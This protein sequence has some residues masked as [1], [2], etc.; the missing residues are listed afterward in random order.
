MVRTILEEYQDFV[1]NREMDCLWGIIDGMM[2]VMIIMRL[3]VCW[4]VL[5]PPSLPH[6][7]PY[8]PSRMDLNKS[9]QYWTDTHSILR[10]AQTSLLKSTVETRWTDCRWIPIQT[11]SPNPLCCQ[12]CRSA[13]HSVPAVSSHRSIPYRTLFLLQSWQHRTITSWRVGLWGYRRRSRRCVRGGSRSGGCRGWYWSGGR[14][15]GCLVLPGPLRR[16]RIGTSQCFPVLRRWRIGR[17]CLG[18]AGRACVG[19]WWRCVGRGSRRWRIQLGRRGG[20]WSR[21]T[22]P[23]Y[24]IINTTLITNT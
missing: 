16:G 2:M 9:C 17:G 23:A 5:S 7:H 6:L 24:L 19:S 8:T 10:K 22:M 11:Y 12:W 18:T 21:W 15:G 13:V 1:R 14:W 4:V 20:G 3:S